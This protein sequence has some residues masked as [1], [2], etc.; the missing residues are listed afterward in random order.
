LTSTRRS[1]RKEKNTDSQD[2]GSFINENRSILL[3]YFALLIVGIILV[4]GYFINYFNPPRTELITID[5]EIYNA[6]ELASELGFYTA[7]IDKTEN[8]STE[9]ILYQLP[10]ILKNKYI[11]NKYGE[12]LVGAPSEAE[13][14]LRTSQLFRI[15]AEIYQSDQS[16]VDIILSNIRS[17]SGLSREVIMDYS[18]SFI[19]Q[20]KIK[21]LFSED[22]EETGNLSFVK[23]IVIQGEATSALFLADYNSGK[24]IDELLTFYKDDTSIELL[25]IGWRLTG[26]VGIDLPDELNVS[27]KLQLVGPFEVGTNSYFY[28]FEKQEDDGLITEPIVGH[29]EDTKLLSF[30]N[31]Q[32]A[33]IYYREIDLDQTLRDYIV[34]ESGKIKLKLSVEALESSNQDF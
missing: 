8:T 16:I 15:P 19:M 27:E 5:D 32:I 25:D 11:L 24:T 4:F 33:N 14:K 30:I 6:K 2:S 21:G 22:L 3:S 23:R 18:R 20:E 31:S 9:E 17:D 12:E 7:Y 1:R 28:Y 13:I 29:Y 26:F 10:M 34:I